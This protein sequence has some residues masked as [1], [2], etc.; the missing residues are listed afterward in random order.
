MLRREH[1][2]VAKEA[3]EVTELKRMNET[4]SEQRIQATNDR[5]HFRAEAER[6]AAEL[7]AENGRRASSKSKISDV[8]KLV[9]KRLR[10]C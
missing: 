3:K 4:L 6:Y 7:S 8:V 5:A 1:E 10:K 9:Y 2:Q